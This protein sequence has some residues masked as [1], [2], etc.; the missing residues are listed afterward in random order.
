MESGGVFGHDFSNRLV[1]RGGAGMAYNGVA[2]SNTLDVRLTLRLLAT[3]NP[4]RDRYQI[5]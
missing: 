1:I 3:T 5:H 2:Q 4:D